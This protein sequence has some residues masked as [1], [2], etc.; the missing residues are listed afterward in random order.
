MIKI[1]VRNLPRSASEES[2][3]A[4]FSEYG[5]VRGFTI[6]KDLFSGDCKGFATVD[7]EGHEARAAIDALDGSE[8]DGRQIY[9]SKDR[10][11]VKGAPRRGRR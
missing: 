3:K 8:F 4:L 11:R 7:M 6:A 2:I 1:S 10:P 9:V 5:T